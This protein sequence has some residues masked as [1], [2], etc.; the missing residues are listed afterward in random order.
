MNRLILTVFIGVAL[1]TSSAFAQAT[2]SDQQRAKWLKRFP[3]AD[4]DKDGTLSVEEA[5]SFRKRLQS[6]RKNSGGSKGV[7]RDFKVDPGWDKP[8]FPGR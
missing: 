7:K 5:N 2:S 4:I 1:A 8:D 6:N 3:V